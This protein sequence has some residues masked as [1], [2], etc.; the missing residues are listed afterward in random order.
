MATLRVFLAALFL[1]AFVA[2]QAASA[3]VTNNFYG[4]IVHVSVENIKV[5]DPKAHLTLSFVLTP[6]FDQVFSQDGK[7]TYQMSKLHKGQYVR[8][9][10]DQKALG[11]RH[12]DKIFIMNNANQKMG[13]Q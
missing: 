9:V 3:G 10:Y 13:T 11:M 6:K 8:V 1:A 2:P 12:A 7:T 5:Y 4:D